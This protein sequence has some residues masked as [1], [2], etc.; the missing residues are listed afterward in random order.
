ME[1]EWNKDMC[2]NHI[3]DDSRHRDGDEEEVAAA[4]A[5]NVDLGMT[6]MNSA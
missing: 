4:T 2:Y 6:W 1:L 5:D 3:Y